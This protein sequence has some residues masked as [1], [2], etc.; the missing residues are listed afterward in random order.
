[1]SQRWLASAATAALLLGLPSVPVPPY[2]MTSAHAQAPTQVQI[3]SVEQL[4]A[5][6]A[7]IAL[8]PD[9]LLTQ[10]FMATSY[11]DQL[12]AARPVAEDAARQGMR[13]AAVEQAVARMDWDPSV[14]SL[15]P[16]PQV[17]TQLTTQQEWTQQLAY[18][19]AV[20]QP[21]VLD[22]VQRLRHAAFRAGHLR[23]TRE[24]GVRQEANWIYIEPAQPSVVY[25]PVYNPMV[26]YGSWSSNYQPVYFP[27]PPNYV[28]DSALAAGIGFA[29]GVAIAPALWDIGRPR[30][31]D[32]D[33][34]VNV[35]RYNQVNVN[36]PPLQ[37][38]RWQA[39]VEHLRQGAGFRP[40][41]QGRIGEPIRPAH[42]DRP[43]APAVA[44]PSAADRGPGASPDRAP[45]SGSAPSTSSSL[46]PGTAPGRPGVREGAQPSPG[47]PP[48]TAT[49]GQTPSQR[50]MPGAPPPT[51]RAEPGA[52]P[53]RPGAPGTAQSPSGTAPGAVVTP[54]EGPPPAPGS[55]QQGATVPERVQPPGLPPRGR[56]EPGSAQTQPQPP[57]SPPGSPGAGSPG[58][59]GRGAGPNV[60]P[61]AGGPPS[62]SEGAGRA[63]PRDDRDRS[64]ALTPHQEPGR[65]AAPGG[66]GQAGRPPGSPPSGMSSGMPP[67]GAGPGATSP[68]LGSRQPMQAPDGRGSAQSEG[69][70]RGGGPGQAQQPRGGQQSESDQRRPDQQPSGRP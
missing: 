20:Q 65:G 67:G 16:F 35:T 48:T 56:A 42:I 23:P 37:D 19:V 21:D 45:G 40:P 2:Q 57:G 6:L 3:Y 55:T 9:P 51:G 14:K 44:Q 60:M 27:P 69:P 11:P 59:P 54:R 41:P 17:L 30:W 7:P 43:G 33:I 70:G 39:P 38:Q 46:P 36:R 34:R 4:D 18:A 58:A 53:Q 49:P 29:A 5:L 26:V 10:I 1:M 52:Q 32:R 8:Y 63:G 68:S 61:P 62:P 66:P 50:T 13:G 12:A 25:V 31:Q 22:S 24:L 28:S 64:G 47:T 15:V